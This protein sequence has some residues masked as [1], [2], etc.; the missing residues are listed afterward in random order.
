MALGVFPTCL[1]SRY[2]KA[3]ARRGPRQPGDHKEVFSVKRM[4]LHLCMSPRMLY[5]GSAAITM[6]ISDL[7]RPMSGALK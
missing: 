6:V 5:D 7:G 2:S 1:W 4:M 3:I